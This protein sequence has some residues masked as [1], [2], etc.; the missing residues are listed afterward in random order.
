MKTLNQ[1]S[2]KPRVSSDEALRVARLDAEKVYRDLSPYRVTIV[3]EADGWHVDYEL[4]NWSFAK[5]QWPGVITPEKVGST[6]QKIRVQRISKSPF[7]KTPVKN[8]NAQGGGP[9]YLVD[10][11]SGAILKKRYTQ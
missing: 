2:T 5:W 9:H 11:A 8:S 3:L 4:K 10:I 1:E 7:C 6:P